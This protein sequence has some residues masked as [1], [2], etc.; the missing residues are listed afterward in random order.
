ME[1]LSGKKT[2]IVVIVAG[3]VLVVKSLKAAGLPA[4]QSI[5]DGV[6][7]YVLAALGVTSVATIRAGIAKTE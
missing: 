7:D 2:Y 4:L 1:W 6:F 3:V 5:P